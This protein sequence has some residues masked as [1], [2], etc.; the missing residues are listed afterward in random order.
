MARNFTDEQIYAQIEGMLSRFRT[1]YCR[2]SLQ[3]VQLRRR[4][5]GRHRAHEVCPNVM[6]VRVMCSGRVDPAFVLDSFR[7]GADG[8]LVCGCHFG[9]CHYV[10]GNHKCMRRVA[11]TKRILKGM[12]IQPERLAF[13]MGVC[14]GR[15]ALSGSSRQLHWK[16]FGRWGR[17]V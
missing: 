16:R 5:S 10:E 1:T 9:D 11:I 17:C 8:V 7:A 4:R 6:T 13:G 12:G 14:F 3:L 2:I 15:R